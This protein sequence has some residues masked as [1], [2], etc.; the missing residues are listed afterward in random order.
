M[1]E[2]ESFHWCVPSIAHIHADISSL[3]RP[4]LRWADHISRGKKDIRQS[5]IE[6]EYVPGGTVGLAKVA[7]S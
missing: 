6:M 1:E 5:A 3:V 7:K 2:D 4:V